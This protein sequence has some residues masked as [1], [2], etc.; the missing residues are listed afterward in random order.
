MNREESKSPQEAT[1]N[2]LLNVYSWNQAKNHW[3]NKEH[4]EEDKGRTQDLFGPDEAQDK[5]A[6]HYGNRY[7]REKT[8]PGVKRG[9][10]GDEL[11]AH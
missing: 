11:G 9:H 10:S 4:C 7:K 1:K 2:V 5:G 6:I 3:S 8:F